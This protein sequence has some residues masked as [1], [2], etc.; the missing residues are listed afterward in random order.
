MHPTLRVL[1]VLTLVLRAGAAG[2]QPPKEKED[3]PEVVTGVVKKYTTDVN[4]YEDGRV[5]TKYTIVLKVETVERTTP[6]SNRNL[7]EGDTITIRWSTVQRS[8]EI[9]GYS[10]DVKEGRI[11]R[12]WLARYCGSPDFYIIHNAKGLEKIPP[13]K[14]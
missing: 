13:H 8:G 14:P 3:A 4:S 5:I 6:D 12:A 1:L 7:K 10:Y 11:V 2:A 9:V